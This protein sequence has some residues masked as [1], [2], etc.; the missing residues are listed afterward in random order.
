MNVRLLIRLISPRDLRNILIG[1]GVTVGGLC[2]AAVTLYAHSIG[3]LRLAG[4]LAGVSLVFV[5]ILLIFVVPPLARNASREASHLNLP[6]EFT[7]GGTIMLILVA[8]VCFSAWNTGNNLL[9]IVLSFMLSSL[10]V[11]FFAGRIALRKTDVAVRFP[12][13]CYAGQITPIVVTATNRKRFF[14]SISIVAELRGRESFPARG[15]K[16]LAAALPKFIAKQITQEPSV[17][18][19]LAHFIYVRAGS[20][21]E[22][23][24]PYLFEHRSKLLVRDIEISTAFP[25]GFFRHRRRV[26]AT[27]PELYVLPE[28]GD[29][30]QFLHGS[31]S[32][33]GTSA[34]QRQGFGGELIAL[35]DYVPTDGIRRIDW[36]ATAKTYQLTVREFAADAAAS[37]SVIF[38]TSWELIDT[39]QDPRKQMENAMKP[40]PRFENGVRITA[41]ILTDICIAGGEFAFTCGSDHVEMAAGHRNLIECLRLLAAVQPSSE[42]ITNSEQAAKI[43]RISQKGG[44]S[45][46]LL[47]T[48]N[49]SGEAVRSSLQ[50]LQ[51]IGY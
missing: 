5:L 44:N 10:L 50:K 32:L 14:P 12:A 31:R 9:F 29:P 26:A 24:V 2:L 4:I 42:P 18:H 37:Y 8:V 41:A 46:V 11:C 19:T 23:V 48:A 30:E 33:G 47:I 6:F 38:D 13:E 17:R 16:L 51:I 45:S 20:T 28:N 35:R 34:A 36:K 43:E 40:D 3:D 21:E 15:A 39:D 1:A 27:D 49:G 22:I 7:T 25:F